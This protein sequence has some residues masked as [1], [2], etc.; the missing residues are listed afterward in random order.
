MTGRKRLLA[1]GSNGTGQLG[2]GHTEDVS[3]W[4]VCCFADTAAGSSDDRLC[5]DLPGKVLTIAS[6]AS[7]AILLLEESAEQGAPTAAQSEPVSIWTT[8]SN[9]FGQ[10][11]TSYAVDGA[12]P[13][14][15][16]WKRLALDPYLKSVG[17][18]LSCRNRYIPKDIACSW[19][20]TFICFAQTE[21]LED[22]DWQ[23]Q[24]DVII[25]FGTNDFGELGAGVVQGGESS[26]GRSKN[27]VHLVKF[28]KQDVDKG[29][30]S[31]RKMKASHRNIACIVNLLPKG[32]LSGSGESKVFGW[33]AGRHGQLD[34]KTGITAN[35]RT[36]SVQVTD[37]PLRSPGS[38]RAVATESI[39]KGTSRRGLG[40]VKFKKSEFPSSLPAPVSVDA[41]SVLKLDPGIKICFDDLAVGAGHIILRVS[42]GE[43]PSSNV[44]VG[45]GNNAK[46][47]LSFVPLKSF[48][49]GGIACTWNGTFVT[50]LDP[51]PQIYTTGANTHGQLGYEDSASCTEN[52][53][54][55]A[56]AA[57]KEARVVDTEWN[58]ENLDIVC[59]SEH[60]IVL[61]HQSATR[62]KAWVW[63]WN[64][65]GNLGLGDVQDR[66]TPTG[67]SLDP[68]LDIRGAW[69]G[70]GTSWIAVEEVVDPAR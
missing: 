34:P 51:A 10:L 30:I 19:T 44:V 37:G 67:I 1:S 14:H 38:A 39:G 49:L 24:S 16:A 32:G 11:G 9:E 20:T 22:G 21:Q 40:G 27:S 36:S 45:F 29:I 61:A 42:I 69:A 64:E 2:I 26:S 28:S 31:V 56:S 33:G 3:T 6:G 8:G 70:C 63:G 62:T 13:A 43:D 60:V 48:N 52:G 50:V 53:S 41:R 35:G 66:W 15:V 4:T 46:S 54:Q 65:H 57:R 25:S 5:K 12:K 17:L 68:N 55:T 18:E 58:A 7:H 23:R 59:G 47:Q